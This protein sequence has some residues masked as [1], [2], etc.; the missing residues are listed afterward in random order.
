M[1]YQRQDLVDLIIALTLCFFHYVRRGP[2]L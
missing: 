2:L 1:S